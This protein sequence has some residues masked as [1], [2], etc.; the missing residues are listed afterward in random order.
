MM[1]GPEFKTV[2]KTVLCVTQ[3]EFARYIG[4]DENTVSRWVRGIH[5]I[6]GEVSTLI[7][8]MVQCRQKLSAWNLHRIGLR[9]LLDEPEP[10]KEEADDG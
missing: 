3:L 9:I 4:R 5:E 1:T 2:L 10:V 6:P 8:L 7:E